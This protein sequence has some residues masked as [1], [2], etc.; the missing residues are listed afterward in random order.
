MARIEYLSGQDALENQEEVLKWLQ[1][2]QP[3]IIQVQAY[4]AK[5]PVVKINDKVE[6]FYAASILIESV[7]RGEFHED[8][9]LA[10]RKDSIYIESTSPTEDDG[11]NS[12]TI[13]EVFFEVCSECARPIHQADYGRCETCNKN[14]ICTTCLAKHKKAKHTVYSAM[15]E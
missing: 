3:K 12:V 10:I 15:D 2:N 11:E 7:S 5:A 4:L 6:A 9:L 14:F 1:T 8:L 13:G